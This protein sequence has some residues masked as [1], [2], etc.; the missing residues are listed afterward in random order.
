MQ[1]LISMGFSYSAIE[2]YDKAI[3]CYQKQLQIADQIQDHRN[4][5]EAFRNIGIVYR[6]Q[7]DY[8]KAIQS[9]QQYLEVARQ[10]EYAIGEGTALNELAMDFYL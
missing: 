10:I 2:H 7:G 3:E 5:A 9:H 4:I 1:A 8:H 6:Q